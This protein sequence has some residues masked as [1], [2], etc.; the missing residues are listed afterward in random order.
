[1]TFLVL[2]FAVY[3]QKDIVNHKKLLEQNQMALVEIARDFTINELEE[4]VNDIKYLNASP[5]FLEYINSGTGKNIVENEWAAFSGSKMKYDQ[6][7]YLDNNGNELLRINFN[8]GKP[9]IVPENRL[10][11]KKDRYYFTE[12]IKLGP[13]KIYMS[14]F[15]LNIEGNLIEQPEKPMIRFG[16]PVFNKNNVKTG[17]FVA[18]YL[19]EKIKQDFLNLTDSTA[20]SL[21][22]INKEGYWLAGPDKS[23]EWGFMYPGRENYT[24]KNMFPSEWEHIAKEKKGHIFTKNGSFAFDTIN[25]K[26]ELQRILKKEDATSSGIHVSDIQWIVICYA[27]DKTFYCA[28]DKNT[29]ILSIT[30]TLRAPLILI[31]LA[32]VSLFFSIISVLYMSGNKK[33]KIMAT[34]DSMTGCLNRATGMKMLENLMQQRNDVI[35]CF[36]DINGLKEINDILGHEQGDDLILTSVKIIRENTRENDLLIRLGGDEFLICFLNIGIDRV[37]TTWLRILDKIALVNKEDKPYII[38]LSHG[39]AEIK[40]S[41]HAMLDEVIREADTKMYDEKRAIKS[42]DFSVIKRI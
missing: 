1:M 25:P 24:F 38:S 4:T 6:L 29:F 16:T 14:K 27:S 19:G 12:T 37:E 34:Y 13:G 35:I 15:D 7:R 20:V 21:Q 28:N 41:D 40:K 9:E 3:K 18:N 31:G 30:N 8:K 23:K 36:I 17:I 5:L 11:N 33:I 2:A 42:A 26:E 22:L 32:L 39:I 10:Q